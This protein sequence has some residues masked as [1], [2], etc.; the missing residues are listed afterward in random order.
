MHARKHTHV[1]KVMTTVESHSQ[2]GQWQV[3]W[4]KH[5]C[6]KYLGVTED[7]LGLS[8]GPASLTSPVLT[9]AAG[10]LARL[11]DTC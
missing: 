1:E 3:G 10:S 7:A 4:L 2:S 6:S 5:T 9:V 11:K 8:L